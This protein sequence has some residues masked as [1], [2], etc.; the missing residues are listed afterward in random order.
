MKKELNLQCPYKVYS[1]F[2]NFTYSFTTKFEVDYTIIFVDVI[3]NFS[4]TSS[5]KK[6]SRI[7]SLN[8]IR[9]TNIPIQLDINIEKTIIAIL[10]H[11]FENKN[12]S[13][14]YLCDV[15]DFKQL[16]RKLKFDLWFEKSKNNENFK[17]IDYENKIENT[18]YF[19]SLIFHHENPMA[20]DLENSFYEYFKSLDK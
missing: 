10:D 17:K 19:S 15:E 9:N 12:N 11:F 4:N 2:E 5:G 1:D 18:S 7:F 14:I 3:S 8:L 13:L 6:L 20:I 16:K